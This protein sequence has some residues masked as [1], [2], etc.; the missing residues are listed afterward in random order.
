[1]IIF[2]VII[3]IPALGQGMED[4]RKGPPGSDD[5]ESSSMSGSDSRKGPLE[6][7][8]QY[9][10]RTGN[11]TAS[12]EDE[13]GE[14]GIELSLEGLKHS[15]TNGTSTID[16]GDLEWTVEETNT[17]VEKTITYQA[18]AD[19]KDEIGEVSGSSTIMMK[20]IYKWEGEKKSIDMDIE[21]ENLPG[22][23]ELFLDIALASEGFED[24][25]ETIEQNQEMKGH[26]YQ[27]HTTSG[28]TLGEIVI[29]EEAEMEA[30]GIPESVNTSVNITS[31][32]EGKTLS[33]SS[34]LS[35]DTESYS[36]TGSLLIFEELLE[37]ITEAGKEAVSYV[38][39]HIVS[40]S[41]GVSTIAGIF[42]GTM[43]FL[44]RKKWETK[45]EDLRL[46]N[47]RYYRRA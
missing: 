23:G 30:S 9:R 14:N 32:T 42:I 24:D 47:N 6:K 39:D 38:M 2:M 13:E 1:M 15:G 17:T 33:I 44:S 45:G 3:S 46:L 31:T 43:L 10:Y 40:F 4:A 26:R 29:D 19:W 25:L 8:Y 12:L 36:I 37:T 5:E 22:E 7:G 35:E 16:T 21:V 18:T 20:Y 41:I 11:P 27:Y 34:A 28:T